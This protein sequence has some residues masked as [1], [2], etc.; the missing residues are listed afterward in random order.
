MD[1]SNIQLYD[2]KLPQW[3]SWAM[4]SRLFFVR[5][6]PHYSAHMT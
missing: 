1:D 5:I 3:I 2:P 4:H 6:R